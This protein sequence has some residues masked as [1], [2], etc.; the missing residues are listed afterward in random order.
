MEM[1]KVTAKGQITIPIAIRKKLGIQEG[2]RV[3]FI[4]RQDGV[5]LINP[6]TLNAFSY[7]ELQSLDMQNERDNTVISMTKSSII[8]TVNDDFTSNADVP[9][10]DADINTQKYD[11]NAGDLLDE[12][13][14]I[15]RKANEK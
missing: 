10:K 9:K 11:F 12:I 2:D 8:K 6:N 4:D 13:R 7:E 5:L 15:G 14:S 1:A 3:L